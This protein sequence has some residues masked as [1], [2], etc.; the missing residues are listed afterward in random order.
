VIITECL[1]ISPDP[2]CATEASLEKSFSQGG[3]GYL[4]ILEPLRGR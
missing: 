3:G 2:S 1:N 4:R